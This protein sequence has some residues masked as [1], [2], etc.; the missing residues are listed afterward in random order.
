MNTHALKQNSPT[1][2]AGSAAVT[3]V[4]VFLP[5]ATGTVGT[6][7]KAVAGSEISTGWV[8]LASAALSAGLIWMASKGRL[9]RKAALVG[10]IL[11]LVAFALTAIQFAIID[12]PTDTAARIGI[13]YTRN[14]GMY[15]VTLTT[16]IGAIA[17]FWAW[18]RARPQDA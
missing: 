10:F 5:W 14:F 7:E 13:S 15:L 12:Q 17:S 4:A 3:A 6:L 18:R 11:S 9:S 2:L 8:V 1:I 16:L